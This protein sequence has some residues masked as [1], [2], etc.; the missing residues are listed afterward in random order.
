MSFWE[1]NKGTF[2]AAGLATAKGFGRGTTA[3]AKGGCTTYQNHKGGNSA[4][5]TGADQEGESSSPSVSVAPVPTQTL[6]SLPPPPMRNVGT[7]GVPVPGAH[8]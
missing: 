6:Q 1:N 7:F 8:P 2:K 3:V 4:S 5:Q